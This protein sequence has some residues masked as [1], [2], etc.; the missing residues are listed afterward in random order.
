MGHRCCWLIVDM[1]QT[2]S[3]PCIDPDRRRDK[4]FK[5]RRSV[6]MRFACC[7]SQTDRQFVGVLPLHEFCW[8]ILLVTDPSIVLCFQQRRRRA[9]ARERWTCRSFGRPHYGRPFIICEFI[10]HHPTLI[11]AC[12]CAGWHHQSAK[13]RRARCKHADSTSVFGA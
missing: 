12:K 9:D 1:T 13:V 10:G 5:A 11:G 2:G 4:S 8:S 3:E 7:K 6:V